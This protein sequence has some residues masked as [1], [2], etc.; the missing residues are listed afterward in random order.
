MS[1]PIGIALDPAPW[2]FPF[3]LSPSSA[4]SAGGYATFVAPIENDPALAGLLLHAQWAV[5]D[6]SAALG[7]RVSPVASFSLFAP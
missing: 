6:P 4:T 3:V 1:H 7:F 5:A 2:L